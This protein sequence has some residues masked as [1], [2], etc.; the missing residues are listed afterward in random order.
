MWTAIGYHLWCQVWH[1]VPGD[2][3]HRARGWRSSTGRPASYES[4]LQDTKVRGWTWD[5]VSVA[6]LSSPSQWC[7]SWK[8]STYF[9]NFGAQWP[10]IS[11]CLFCDTVFIQWFHFP[12]LSKIFLLTLS[13]FSFLEDLIS[14]NSSSFHSW[15]TPKFVRKAL[16]H[17]QCNSDL[18]C[19]TLSIQ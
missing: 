5:T 9:S 6:C 18:L 1:M 10:G 19:F 2:H 13:V 14:E 4:T 15:S 16:G 12:G 3:S 8:Y 11:F 17:S 7:S